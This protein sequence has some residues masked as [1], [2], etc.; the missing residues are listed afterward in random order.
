MDPV[1]KGLGPG[2]LKKISIMLRLDDQVARLKK[3]NNSEK[4]NMLKVSRFITADE[5]VE[6][7][8][9]RTEA[10][11]IVEAT[12]EARKLAKAQRKVSKGTGGVKK[13]KKGKKRASW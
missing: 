8:Q 9:E 6:K 1:L 10:K 12:K 11:A 13:P 7:F 2:E 5:W 3:V 4:L